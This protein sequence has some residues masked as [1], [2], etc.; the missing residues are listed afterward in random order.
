MEPEQI[1]NPYGIVL[2]K[3]DLK[4][5]KPPNWLNDNC[6]NFYYSHLQH[7]DFKHRTDFLFMDPV[8]VS[9][10]M[11]QCEGWLSEMGG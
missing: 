8:V 10:M 4:L 1:P 3:S 7:Q 11:V 6:I 2:Y 9:C 5:L